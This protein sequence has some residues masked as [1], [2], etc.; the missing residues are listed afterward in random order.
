MAIICSQYFL[1][2]NPKFK[3]DSITFTYTLPDLKL[4]VHFGL[5][6][7]GAQIRLGYKLP[8]DR[9]Q[10]D[11]SL[12][13]I[14]VYNHMV[15]ILA[16]NCDRASHMQNTIPVQVHDNP[17]HQASFRSTMSH[18]LMVRGSCSGGESDL[19]ETICYLH[20]HQGQDAGPR[21]FCFLP[22]S[23]REYVS[24]LDWERSPAAKSLNRP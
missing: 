11:K 22:L 23:Q 13:T 8:F 24:W 17:I 5:F 6:L 14:S 12:G 4:W 10:A 9:V 1:L 18:F 15:V 16:F 3:Q 19:D 21:E 2:S 7:I 20:L